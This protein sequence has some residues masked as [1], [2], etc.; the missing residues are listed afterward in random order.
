VIKL[1]K[2]LTLAPYF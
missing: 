1:K 2:N